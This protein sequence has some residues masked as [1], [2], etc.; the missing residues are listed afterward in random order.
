MTNCPWNSADEFNDIS[1]LN[2]YGLVQQ[3]GCSPEEAV[4][5]VGEYSRDNARTPFPWNDGANAGFTTGKPWLKVNPSYPTVNAAAERQD[6]L[7]VLAYYKKLVALRKAP[8]TSG[9]LGYG[10][11]T[12]CLLEYDDVVAYVREEQGQKNFGGEPLHL[13]R[14]GGQAAL[15][16]PQGIAD[17]LSAGGYSGR[18]PFPEALPVNCRGNLIR[19]FLPA[20][21]KGSAGD[22]I[23]GEQERQSMARGTAKIS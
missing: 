21:R 15:R 16:H 5:V 20:E 1:T 19:C 12:P 11:I 4:K 22:P 14:P 18:Y 23:T 13:R 10:S 6:P 8:A 17:Q 9:P 2:Q 7:P 3:A